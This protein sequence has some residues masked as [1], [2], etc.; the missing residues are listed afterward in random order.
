MPDAR[1][2]DDL[3]LR[4]RTNNLA[5]V[6][7]TAASAATQQHIISTMR[8]LCKQWCLEARNYNGKAVFKAVG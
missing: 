6:A 2:N 1:W 3:L 5:G 8:T 4:F 7:N